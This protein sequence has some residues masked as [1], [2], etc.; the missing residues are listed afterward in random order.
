[1]L[2]KSIEPQ[3]G[4]PL[5]YAATVKDLWDT[6]HKLCLKRQNAS[7]LYTLRKQVHDC[8]QRTLDVTFYFNKLSTL[9]RDGLVQRN[10]MG[11]L[12]RW[13]IVCLT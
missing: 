3:I 4:K 9:A 6:T 1:M 12:E 8:K 5:L 2:I 13:F 11:Y 10:S 7:H